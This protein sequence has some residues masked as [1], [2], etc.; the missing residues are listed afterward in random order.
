MVFL[1]VI[2]LMVYLNL[3]NDGFRIVLIILIHQLPQ[4]MKIFI[5]LNKFMVCINTDC[6]SAVDFVVLDS[7]LK[8]RAFGCTS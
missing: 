2:Q 4:V 8:T 1:K 6:N 7:Q 5:I 3:K